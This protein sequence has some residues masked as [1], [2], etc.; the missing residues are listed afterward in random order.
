M[1]GSCRKR[2]P[3]ARPATEQSED[4][5]NK[6]SAPFPHQP[7]KPARP[8]AAASINCISRARPWCSRS[9]PA[10]QAG[11]SRSPSPEAPLQTPKNSQRR[12]HDVEKILQH[13]ARGRSRISQHSPPVQRNAKTSPELQQLQP[14][15]VRS[16]TRHSAFCRVSSWSAQGAR[17]KLRAGFRKRM[18]SNGT[19]AIWRIWTSGVFSKT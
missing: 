6:K 7:M 18:E 12:A 14:N 17:R 15:A 4:D 3:Q 5:N 1:D 2:S 11:G 9:S 16:N 13:P 8:K 19:N 10:P